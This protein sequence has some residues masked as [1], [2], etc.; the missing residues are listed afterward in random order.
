MQ[1]HPAPW[2]HP[3]RPERLAP[4]AAGVRAGAGEVHSPLEERQ[5][6]STAELLDELLP[7]V[8]EPDH[9]SRLEGLVE[10]GGGWL[11][12]DTYLGP[13]SLAAAR[14]AAG[15]TVDAAL[16]A[17]RGD[18]GVAFAAVRPPGHHAGSARS[19]GFCLL[20]NVAVAV[21]ALRQ[22]GLAQ[23]IAIIDWDV[24]HGDGTQEIFDAD[25]DLC[26]ASTH[27]WPLY[28]GTGLA[29]ERGTGAGEG[30]KHN[31]P[32]GPGSG[33]DAFVPAWLDHLLPEIERFAPEALLVSAGYDAH[34]ADPLAQLQVTEDGYRRIAHGVGSLA[35][36]LG[37]PGVALTL[38][39]G[40]DAHALHAA[41]AATVAG[42]LGGLYSIQGA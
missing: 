11:D 6:A 26:Y 21:A 2:G 17:A 3:E 25:P 28:P 7:E 15:A 38:E 24:H 1:R 29:R 8:H 32:L 39:G 18:F 30:T 16:A 41:S 37:L 33:D 12:A 19:A 4:V 36:R 10:R 14:L 35:A 9:L 31:V 22:E 34:R 5:P 40:Y 13:E 23:R 20:N 27:Q 42:L